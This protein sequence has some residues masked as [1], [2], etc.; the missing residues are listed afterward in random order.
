MRPAKFRV[1]R[2]STGWQVSVPASLSTSGK[3]ERPQ[4]KTRDEAKKFAGKLKEKNREHGT[5]DPVGRE[6]L[7]WTEDEKLPG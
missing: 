4:F 5:S 6:A 2:S 3:R 1:T 7:A